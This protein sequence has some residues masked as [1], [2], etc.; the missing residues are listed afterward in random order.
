MGAI[1]KW[2]TDNINDQ[3]NYRQLKMEGT[4]QGILDRKIGY[5]HNIQAQNRLEGYS[6]SEMCPGQKLKMRSKHV[7]NIGHVGTVL[8]RRGK[9]DST[10]CP[11]CNK[12]ENNEGDT[13]GVILRLQPQLKWKYINNISHIIRN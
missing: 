1:I 8:Y 4:R 2:G 11:R 3:E 13:Y 9:Q 6:T 7:A 10:Q 5:P 12:G